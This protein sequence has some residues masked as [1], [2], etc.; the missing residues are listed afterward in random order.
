MEQ[1]KLIENYKM[2]WRRGLNPRRLFFLKE[3][4]FVENEKPKRK[5]LTRNHSLNFAVT[6][7]ERSMIDQ[8]MAQTGITNRRAYLL[9]MAVDGRVIHVELESVK[10]MVRLLS[11]AT[12]NINQIAKRANETGNIYSVDVDELRL[13]YEEIWGQTKIILKK[14][15]KL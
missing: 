8:R 7:K 10:E 14:L 15:S 13:R 9:K 11:N 1:N 6:E 12:N 4:K 2:F 3:E 5:K